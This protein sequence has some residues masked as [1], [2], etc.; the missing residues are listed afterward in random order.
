M[1]VPSKHKCCAINTIS[2]VCFC[3]FLFF[4]LFL[5][6]FL[7]LD[8]FYCRDDQL[9]SVAIVGNT[10]DHVSGFVLEL[11]G[12]RNNVFTNN[13]ING[14][15]SIHFDNRGGDGTSCAR[16]GQMPFVFLNR[17]PYKS[18]AWSK[19]DDM[20]TILEDAPC[21]PKYNQIENNILCGG[22]TTLGFDVATATQKWGSFVKN[23]T[24][25]AEC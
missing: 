15:G 8:A 16:T 23:N 1:R 11:G 19:Y 3:F 6:L 13:V 4:F 12:G 24:V 10:F 5:F 9:S 25:S 21:T 14:S 7:P 17:V 20:A 2:L 22:V 18:S